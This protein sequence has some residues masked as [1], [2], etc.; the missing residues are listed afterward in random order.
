MGELDTYYLAIALAIASVLRWY[1][2]I[3]CIAEVG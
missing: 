2:P 1:M 3:S